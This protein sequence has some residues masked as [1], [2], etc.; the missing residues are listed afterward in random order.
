M[1]SS[2]LG[3]LHAG[4]YANEG[5]YLKTSFLEGPVPNAIAGQAGGPIRETVDALILEIRTALLSMKALLS[6]SARGFP[7]PKELPQFTPALKITDQYASFLLNGVR[8][9]NI[10]PRMKAVAEDALNSRYAT[11]RPMLA[12]FAAGLD[13]SQT[14]AEA[15]AA[16]LRGIEKL[17]IELDPA[18]KQKFQRAEDLVNTLK[19][20]ESPQDTLSLLV[21]VWRITDPADRGNFKE[22]SPDLYNFFE[23]K[24]E[25]ELDCLAKP[26]CFN[27]VLG[28]AKAIIFKK[29]EE[30]GL[31]KLKDQVDKAGRDG[32]LNSVRGEALMAF[33]MVPTLIQKAMF[34]EAQKYLVLL[35]KVKANPTGFVKS[36][37]QSW[38]QANFNQPLK[39]MET[40]SVKVTLKS[41]EEIL[42]KIGRAHV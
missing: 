22:V 7:W 2:D 11:L 40:T 8:S 29:L 6:E 14:M 25:D 41:R 23:G 35:G 24:S 19:S 3:K 1:C 15:L 21:K 4:F 16:T 32:I 37:I 5:N 13:Q 42:V 10:S 12:E 33:P 38:A 39:G 9:G 31:R 30:Y 27:P 34:A 28:I 20:V 36:H 18:S 26:H 17:G